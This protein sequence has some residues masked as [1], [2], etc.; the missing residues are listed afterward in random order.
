[1]ALLSNPFKKNIRTKKGGRINP[2]SFWN[3]FLIVFLTAFIAIIVMTTLF[4][5]QTVA[6]LDATVL[7]RLDTGLRPVERIRQRI[8]KAEKAV[9]T[10][11]KQGVLFVETVQ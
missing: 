6:H 4:F 9:D 10:R 2:H 11:T 7:P 1:M 3:V 8:E 5:A